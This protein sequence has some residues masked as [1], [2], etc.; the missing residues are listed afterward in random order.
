MEYVPKE[1]MVKHLDFSR[2]TYNEPIMDIAVG[3]YLNFV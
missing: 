1:K 3:K 2:P